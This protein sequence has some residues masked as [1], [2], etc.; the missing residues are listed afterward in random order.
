MRRFLGFLGCLFALLPYMVFADAETYVTTRTLSVKSATQVA[1]AAEEACRKGGYKVSVAVVDRQGNLLAFVRNPLSGNHTIQVSQD[2]AYT[3]A[4][5]LGATIDLV[6][7]ADFL[8]DADDPSKISLTQ[9]NVRLAILPGPDSSNFMTAGGERDLEKIDVI[10]PVLHG[11]YGED[12]TVQGLLRMADIPFVGAD[13]LG[14]AVGMDKDVM[15]RLLKEA[16]V[17]QAN[18]LS[19]HEAEHDNIKCLSPVKESIS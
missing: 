10:F 4:T 14:S 1:V 18:F 19:Y 16:G 5:L 8:K 9:G 3:S 6:E 15:K 17:P 7:E 12:G 11:P 13:V 2:K